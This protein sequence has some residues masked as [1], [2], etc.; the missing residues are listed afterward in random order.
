MR[1][2]KRALRALAQLAVLAAAET[3]CEQGDVRICGHTPD[4]GQSWRPRGL[5]PGQGGV[6]LPAV[7]SFAVLAQSSEVQI[8]GEKD[9]LDAPPQIPLAS[10]QADGAIL[11]LAVL[12]NG[13]AAVG[14]QEGSINIFPLS[15][16]QDGR[17]PSIFVPVPK[18]GPVQTLAVQASSYL[19][20]GTEDG[21]VYVYE[22]ASLQ[23]ETARPIATVRSDSAGF[24][25]SAV[26][27]LLFLP[28]G[29]L[30]VAYGNGRIAIFNPTALRIAGAPYSILSSGGTTNGLA[31]L[32]SN[33]LAVLTTH[34]RFGTR[35]SSVFLFNSSAVGGSGVPYASFVGIG[36]TSSL[37]PAILALQGG[38]LAVGLESPPG[39][40]VLNITGAP[41]FRPYLNLR[42]KRAVV[43]LAELAPGSLAAGTRSGQ[44]HVF[45]FTHLANGSAANYVLQATSLSHWAYPIVY[46]LSQTHGCVL[47]GTTEGRVDLYEMAMLNAGKTPLVTPL[48]FNGG[49]LSLSSLSGGKYLAVGNPA[50]AEIRVF[51]TSNFKKMPVPSNEE[52]M[53]SSVVLPFPGM[54]NLS[55]EVISLLELPGGGLVAGSEDGHVALWSPAQVVGQETRLPEL[56]QLDSAKITAFA[57]LP[58]GYLAVGTSRGNVH[59]RLVEGGQL[60][61]SWFARLTAASTAP[62]AVTDIKV[63][64]GFL[65]VGLE[66]GGVA[67]YDRSAVKNLE[68]FLRPKYRLAVNGSVNSLLALDTGGLMVGCSSGQLLMF[69][70]ESMTSN[71]KAF[72]QLSAEEGASRLSPI[73]SSVTPL[74]SAAILAGSVIF[75]AVPCPGGTYSSGGGASCSPCLLGWRSEPG[76]VSCS[77]IP[78]P[79]LFAILAVTVV[80]LILS[81]APRIVWLLVYQ[82]LIRREEDDSLGVEHL[83]RV[84]SLRTGWLAMMPNLLAWLAKGICICA[85]IAS[86]ML[87]QE[88]ATRTNQAEEQVNE[89]AFPASPNQAAALCSLLALLVTTFGRHISLQAQ[90]GGAETLAQNLGFALLAMSIVTCFMQVYTFAYPGMTQSAIRNGACQ[91]V[92]TPLGKAC[93]EGTQDVWLTILGSF[94]AA[95]T[96]VQPPDMSVEMKKSQRS[97]IFAAGGRT[98]ERVTNAPGQRASSFPPV[99]SLRSLEMADLDTG[100][101]KEVEGQDDLPG[102][103]AP[104]QG[105]A[106]D[107]PLAAPASAEG[108]SDLKA[109]G[110]RV[111]RWLLLLV[112]D[113]FTTWSGRHLVGVLNSAVNLVL[114]GRQA[115][116]L[117]NGD[118]RQ[119]SLLTCLGLSILCVLQGGLSLL[120][121]NFKMNR[122][123]FL[124]D[125]HFRVVTLL[126][127]ALLMAKSL[128]LA[129]PFSSAIEV[130]GEI[131]FAWSCGLEISCPDSCKEGMRSGETT[132]GSCVQQVIPSYGSSSASPTITCACVGSTGSKLQTTILVAVSGGLIAFLTLLDVVTACRTLNSDREL[133]REKFKLGWVRLALFCSVLLAILQA[134]VCFYLVEFPV[135]CYAFRPGPTFRLAVPM[136]PIAMLLNEAKWVIHTW[137]ADHKRIHMAQLQNTNGLSVLGPVTFFTCAGAALGGLATT[138]PTSECQTYHQIAL[139]TLAVCAVTSLGVQGLEAQ[140]A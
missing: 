37:A 15:S 59:L 14:T 110:K 48:Q 6:H 34:R 120:V 111:L 23:S 98:R 61:S 3:P 128:M 8:V 74:S 72:M 137:R 21:S 38:I 50:A 62:V 57:S 30:A 123:Y 80:T 18:G 49:P 77:W 93:V 71:G 112:I 130:P 119:Q 101:G 86:L 58:S 88:A 35:F 32:P 9:V 134:V 100:K 47:A 4:P 31:P 108:S 107:E 55:S 19:V 136:L 95:A 54:S 16:I 124:A 33:G 97:T 94:L 12:N 92:F 66:M 20:A 10:L 115:W 139:L 75:R 63:L 76:S 56:Y 68:M 60:N 83:R 13:S 24:P 79:V 73:I 69:S 25:G 122:L 39:V 133:Y 106:E 42:T 118:A 91:E 40:V 104:S 116:R 11:C 28:S 22:L 90:N 29:D 17:G 85:V 82:R 135:T 43:S 126:K 138:L 89:F 65:A 132:P 51:N 105:E 67:I 26:D 1:W 109:R 131:K 41:N 140:I 84:R 125:K 70:K 53:N 44:I 81:L 46:G 2:I 78:L 45:N 117:Q 103:L 114:F 96:L 7:A 99:S 127:T 129:F 113:L 52:L 64:D 27:S 121:V 102:R 5:V 87:P 36:I